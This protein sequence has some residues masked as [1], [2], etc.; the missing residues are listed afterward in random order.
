MEKG[1]KI[2]A[3]KQKGKEAKRARLEAAYHAQDW[4]SA[5]LQIPSLRDSRP[6]DNVSGSYTNP[7]AGLELTRRLP[8]PNKS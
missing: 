6:L 5:I 8:S 2:E 7:L 1:K 3:E 4:T